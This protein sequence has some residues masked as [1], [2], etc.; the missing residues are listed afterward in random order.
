MDEEAI[1]VSGAFRQTRLCC[2]KRACCMGLA[3]T[4]SRMSTPADVG[5]TPIFQ[6]S[7]D[8]TTKRVGHSTSMCTMVAQAQP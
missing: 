8:T 2:W 6:L 1:H 7:M 5:H 3:C 4:N